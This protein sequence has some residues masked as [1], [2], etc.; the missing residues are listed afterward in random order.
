MLE[1]E[2]AGAADSGARNLS[3]GKRGLEGEAWL[4]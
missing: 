3:K 2:E 1:L 4:P